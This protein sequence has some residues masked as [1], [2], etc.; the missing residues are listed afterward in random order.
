MTRRMKMTD[1]AFTANLGEL[2]Q[3]AEKGIVSKT[4]Y[5]SPH[6]KVVLFCFEEGQ[7]LS[8]HQAPFEAHI[9]VL[10]GEGDFLL[11]SE[12]APG[13]DGSFFVMPKGLIHAI[14]AKKRLVFLL[15]MIKE[16]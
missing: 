11:G 16:S 5:D 15:T 10:Q 3:F 8:E 13:T 1:K 4:L 2:Y 14:R 9:S 7:S 12:T 6:S